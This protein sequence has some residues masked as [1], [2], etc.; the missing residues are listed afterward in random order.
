[1][2]VIAHRGVELRV[3]TSRGDPIPMSDTISDGHKKS[4]VARIQQN[5]YYIARWR[6]TD[7]PMN[8]ECQFYVSHGPAGKAQETRAMY[9]CMDEATK[10][11]QTRTTRDNLEPPFPKYSM[12]RT[13]NGYYLRLDIRRFSGSND[14]LFPVDLDNVIDREEPYITLEVKFKAPLSSTT[15]QSGSRSRPAKPRPNIRNVRHVPRQAQPD[16]D[17]EDD[18]DGSDGVVRLYCTISLNSL[19]RVTP[20]FFLLRQ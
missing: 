18:S 16:S 9:F 12:L 14:G 19:S 2:L 5:T 6:T 7:K 10:R 11:T 4:A 1:M 3:E 8:L 17:S 15:G 13:Q 20:T